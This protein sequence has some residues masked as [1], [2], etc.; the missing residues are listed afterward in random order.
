M[1]GVVRIGL[2]QLAVGS[3]KPANIAGALSAIK[4]AAARAANIIALPEC[5]NSPYGTAYFEEYAEPIPGPTTQALSAAAKEHSVYVVGGSIPERGS[6]GKLYNT[7]TVFNKAGDLI[8]KH[9]KVHLFDIDVP[10]RIRFKESETLSAGS[11]LTYFDTEYCRV[12][13]GICY[14]IRFPELTQQCAAQGCALMIFPGAFNMTTGPAH[15]ELLQRA[16]AIDNQIFVATVSPA[17]DET[18]S[19]IAWGHTTAVNPWGEVIATCGHEP[20]IV[21]ADL[22]L[23]KVASTRSSIPIL[24]QKRADLYSLSATPASPL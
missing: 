24:Q 3:S 17:R 4:E 9:R 13:L 23:E 6:D 7:S 18:A 20:T 21:Y 15:W 8:A 5:F 2:V 11:K 19:Y 12:G 16:R 14:D 22:D 1:A 10:G